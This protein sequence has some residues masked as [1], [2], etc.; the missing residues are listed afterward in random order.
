MP[1]RKRRKAFDTETYAR[2]F[3]DALPIPPATEADNERL[4]RLLADLDD[5]E[6]PTPEQTAFAELLAIVIE[7]FENRNYALPSVPPHEALAALM[8]DR[9]LQHK[10]LAE[11]IGNKGLTTEIL[12]GRRKISK[13]IAKKL[14]ARFSVPVELF[15]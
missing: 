6:K 9:G 7:D 10:H 1:E 8:E 11:V 2:L 3:R 4:I 14:S 12:A 5:V 13:A 15:I